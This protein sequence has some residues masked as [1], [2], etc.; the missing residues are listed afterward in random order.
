MKLC[1]Y[2]YLFSFLQEVKEAFFKEKTVELKGSFADLVT[3][4]DQRVEKLII[5]SFKEKY[6][7]HKFI[8][9][10]SVAD[11]HKCEWTDDPTWI[12]DPIDG[13]SNFVH[14]VR[15]LGSAAV[16]MCMVAL[17]AG[18]AYVEYGIHVWDIA[19]A[20]LII[21]EAGGIVM[22]PSGIVLNVV[23]TNNNT[24]HICL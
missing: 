10:E 4:T 2:Q 12:I 23:S 3:E 15:A 11:G 14:S 18:E 24:H 19:A 13:T 16:D 21:T 20:A 5:D 9:E 7:T 22:D 1:V 8:G 17:G 6:P